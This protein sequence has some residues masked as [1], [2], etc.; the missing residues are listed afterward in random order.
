MAGEPEGIPMSILRTVFRPLQNEVWERLNRRLDGTLIDR[1]GTLRDELRIKAGSWTVTLDRHCEHGGRTEVLYTRFRAP[2]VNSDGFRFAIF[3]EGIFQNIAK[4]FGLQDIKS[5]YGDLDGAFILQANSETTLRA[6][7][8]SQKFR[9]LLLSEPEIHLHV[10]DSGDWFRE[11]FP[12]GVDEL[13]LEIE[14]EVEEMKR[15][16]RLYDLFCE[17]LHMLCHIGSAYEDDP[18]VDG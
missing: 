3:H 10:R 15:L 9:Q 5:G 6:L 13:V 2:Y 8:T 12:E 4:L 1:D 14:G 16:E 7:C 11:E 18:E 17:T